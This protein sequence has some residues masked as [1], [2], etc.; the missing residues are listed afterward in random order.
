MVVEP[1]A[2]IVTRPV[3]ELTVPTDGTL[4]GRIECEALVAVLG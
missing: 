3:V 2:T 1:A 4:L